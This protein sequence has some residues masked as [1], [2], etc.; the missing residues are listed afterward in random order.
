MD[1]LLHTD[2]A[3]TV[4]AL[5]EFAPTAEPVRTAPA[6]LLEYRHGRHIALPVHASREVLERP[7]VVAVPGT[8]YYCAGM[9]KWQGQWLPVLDLQV[10]L[11]AYRAEHA[12]PTRYLLVVAYQS[13]S[14]QPLRHGV[15]AL[16]VL[17]TTIEVADDALCPLPADSDLWPLLALS[18][19]EHDGQP[20]PVLDAARLFERYHD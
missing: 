11:N 16:P 5:T 17:P 13:A 18:C 4:P 7:Q 1:M 14:F 6:R 19:F 20:V 15:I 12:A 3:P 9:T 10:L 2:F 8:A